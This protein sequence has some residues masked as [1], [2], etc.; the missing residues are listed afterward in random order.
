MKGRCHCNAVK[1]TISKNIKTILNC[2]CKLCRKANG[3]AFST[4]VVVASNEFVKECGD[5]KTIQLSDN[6]SKHVC[7]NC[8]TPIFN[9][10]PKYAGLKIVY[11]GALDNAN[12]LVPLVDTYCE[13]QLKWLSGLESLRKMEKGFG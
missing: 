7:L 5:L 12:Q 9:E 4:Y 13:S 6:A 11:L 10:N 1:F 3:S 8:A 2:H